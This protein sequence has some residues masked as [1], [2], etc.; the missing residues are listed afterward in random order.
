LVLQVVHE[1]IRVYGDQMS[2]LIDEERDRLLANFG[3]VTKAIPDRPRAEVEAE[4]AEIRR[5]RKSGGD[6]PELSLRGR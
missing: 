1:A 2:R 4:L 5:A 6:I 3:E